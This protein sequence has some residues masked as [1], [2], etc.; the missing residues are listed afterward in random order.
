MAYAPNSADVALKRQ[1]TT[2]RLDEGSTFMA[3]DVAW[4]GGG[5]G[6]RGRRSIFAVGAS[7]GRRQQRCWLRICL[8]KI[9]VFLESV[10]WR[11]RREDVLRRMGGD[12]A[13]DAYGGKFW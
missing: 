6:G 13:V 3:H 10:A 7:R 4:R 12:N 1:A 9:S 8:L 11:G 5:V 2:S